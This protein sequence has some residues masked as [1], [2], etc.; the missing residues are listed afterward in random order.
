MDEKYNPKKQQVGDFNY[1]V[2][3]Q[4][5]AQQRRADPRIAAFL[6]QELGD[7]RTVLN[8]GAGAGSYEPEECYVLAVE[9]SAAMRAQRPRHLAPAINGVAEDLPLDNQSVDASMALVTV[10]QWAKLSQGLAELCRVTR[11]SILIL[12]FDRDALDRYWLADYVPEL[13]AVEYRRYPPLQTICNE[14]RGDVQIHTVPIPVDCLDGFTEAFYSR[15]ERFLDPNVRKAQ[16]AW[17]F[18]DKEIEKR[19][20]RTLAEDLRLGI[21][22]E[23]YGEWRNKPF[24]EGSLR[25]IVSRPAS[26]GPS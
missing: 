9:P 7:A 1:E 22:E 5:Y 18:V 16:S 26:G 15:P 10:H 11:G 24:Y 17:G 25:L 23:R 20:S 8:V 21:W 12:T 13:I 14:L 6:N 4:G 19:F 3:G 2:Y